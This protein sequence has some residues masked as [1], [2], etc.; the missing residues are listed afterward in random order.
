MI[1]VGSGVPPSYKRGEKSKEREKRD[2]EVAE[3][4]GLGGKDENVG[5][6]LLASCTWYC[7][8]ASGSQAEGKRENLFKQAFGSDSDT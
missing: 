7:G 4:R 8:T 1:S 3:I 2:V 5:L 6:Y